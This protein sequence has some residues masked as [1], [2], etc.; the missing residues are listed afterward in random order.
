MQTAKTLIVTA[1]SD[2]KPYGTHRRKFWQ[3]WL[4]DPVI[5]QLT[6]GVT[7]QK[8]SL[9]LAVGSA[10]ALF[11]ILGTTTTLCVVAGIALQLN[12]PILQGVN[13]LCTIIYFPFMVACVRLGDAVAGTAR[14]SLDIPL[15]ISLATNHP[16]DFLRQFG[17]TALHAMLGWAI[18]APVWLPLVYFI[19][20]PPLRAVARRIGKG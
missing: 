8:V 2:P 5:R 20:L 9:S 10:L 17:V 4:T 19:A 18:V 11:P 13:L 1:A 12:Q 3:R 16:R 6:Q 15:M 7:P 14:S